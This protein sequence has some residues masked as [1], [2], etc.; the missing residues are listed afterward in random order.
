MPTGVYE[1]DEAVRD[2]FLVPP[3]Q[4]SVPLKYRR[5]GIRY[6]ELSEEDKEQGGT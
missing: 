1:L 6:D 3:R 5:E 2:G 4:L